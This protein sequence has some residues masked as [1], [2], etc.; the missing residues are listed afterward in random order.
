MTTGSAVVRPGELPLFDFDTLQVGMEL[1][2]LETTISQEEVARFRTAV[3]NPA[4]EYFTAGLRTTALLVERHF[5]RP[6]HHI[7]SGLD[8]E[9]FG[10]ARPGRL[11]RATARIAD[12]Y[13]KREKPYIAIDARLFDE[14]GTLVERSRRYR[15]VAMPAAIAKWSAESGLAADRAPRRPETAPAGPPEV[16][17][18]KQI[19]IEKL[20]LFE[21]IYAI[22]AAK[23]PTVHSDAERAHAAGLTRPIGSGHLLLAYAH[24]LVDK[25]FGSQW[26]RGGRLSLRFLHA[27][28]DGDHLVFGAWPADDETSS[29]AGRSTVLLWCQNQRG[30]GVARGS[31]SCVRG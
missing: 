12:K 27:F 16:S 23:G 26:V 24:E 29:A 1:G 3:E 2:S 19:T 22:V 14:D 10:R 28:E 6:L 9:Y 18:E 4:A 31:A 13:V 21:A 15:M 11:L 7:N 25:A 8:A 20:G 30:Q 5:R 17:I